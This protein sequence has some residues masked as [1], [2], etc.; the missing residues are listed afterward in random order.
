MLAGRAHRDGSPGVPCGWQAPLLSGLRLASDAAR[1]DALRRAVTL[2]LQDG[3]VHQLVARR[4]GDGQPRQID[5]R[6]MPGQGR[7]LDR[8]DFSEQLGAAA[9]VSLVWESSSCT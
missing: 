5:A 4:A 8:D 2:Q 9:G 3:L 6:G 1:N 7:L